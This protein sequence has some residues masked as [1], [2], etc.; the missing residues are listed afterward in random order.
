MAETVTIKLGIYEAC[1]FVAS[2]RQRKQWF[3]GKTVGYPCAI[4]DL[5][6]GNAIVITVQPAIDEWTQRNEYSSPTVYWP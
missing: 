4:E 1:L 6:D 3:D 2:M 5:N